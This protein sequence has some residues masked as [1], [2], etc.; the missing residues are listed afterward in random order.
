MKKPQYHI[1]VCSSFRGSEPKGVCHAK[2]AQG[3]LPYLE[4]ELADRGLDA[5]VSSTSCLKV[6]DNGPALVVYPQGDWYGGVDE[7]AVDAIL[8]ALAE[9][10]AATE[11]LLGG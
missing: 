2:G 5:L 8:D 10:T 9:G 11:Y 3:L 4:S 7:E 1:L 6:C